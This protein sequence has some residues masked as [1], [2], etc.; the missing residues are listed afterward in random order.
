MPSRL[1]H[2][3]A[4]VTHDPAQLDDVSADFEALGA[5]L[6]AAEA[7]AVAARAYRRDGLTRRASDASQRAAR[8]TEVCEG[9]Q[10]PVLAEGPEI[11]PLTRRE[12]EV[13]ELA[14]RGMTSREVAEKLFVSTRTVENHLQRAYD[15]LGVSGRAELAASLG[16]APD[17]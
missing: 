7:A 17:T 8:L 5:F 6:L 14:A 16:V 4:L 9:A 10:T 13:A 3:E 12:R 11:V 1:R 15:K 2:V